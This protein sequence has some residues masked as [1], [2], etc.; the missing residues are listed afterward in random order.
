MLTLSAQGFTL[1]TDF[2]CTQ[3]YCEARG[4]IAS[5]SFR[6]LQA[7]ANALATRLGLGTQ[8]TVDGR[9]G[10][11]TVS[12]IKA[13]AVK[14]AGSSS[15][16]ASYWDTSKEEVSRDAAL[17][18]AEIGLLLQNNAGASSPPPPPGTPPSIPSGTKPNTVWAGQI[19]PSAGGI[20]PAPSAGT[21][22]TP[23]GPVLVPQTKTKYLL[24]GAAVLIGSITAGLAISRRRKSSSGGVSG[25]RPRKTRDE[26]RIEANYGYGH[27]WEYEVAESTREEAKKRLREYRENAPQY[28]YRLVKK[29]VRA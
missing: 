15:T 2:S 4:L 13:L 27:G 11:E 21:T 12:L 10:R 28:S 17:L 7:G 24:A 23:V 6:A 22:I 9:I 18:A 3:S 8:I 29:R 16:L 20:A 19:V 14:V 26:Y 25:A 1:G 5:G